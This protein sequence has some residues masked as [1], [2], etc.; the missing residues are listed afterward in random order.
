M[1]YRA[2]ARSRREAAERRRVLLTAESYKNGVMS[3]T[4]ITEKKR[5]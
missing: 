5:S 2:A 3:R 4:W 1:L